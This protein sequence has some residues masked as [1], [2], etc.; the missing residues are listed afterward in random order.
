MPRKYP[1]KENYFDNINSER[2]AYFLGFIY[3]DGCNTPSK[4][5]LEISLAAQDEDI[6]LEISKD[7]LCGNNGIRRYKSKRANSQ[8]RVALYIINKRISQSLVKQGCVARKT[9]TLTFPN[10]LKENLIRHFIRGYFDGDGSLSIL[11][12]IVNNKPYKEAYLS[13][14]GTKEFLMSLCSIFEARGVK[15]YLTK[16]F[17]ERNNNNYTLR[18]SGN[19][20]IVRATQWLYEGSKIC[21]SRKKAMYNTLRQL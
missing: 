13:F 20:Q 4:N 6:L 16:R 3:A 7:I 5:R 14:V 18:V 10:F 8:D 17:P 1:I 21:L 19:R 15:S 12:R 2:K 9:F 11:N